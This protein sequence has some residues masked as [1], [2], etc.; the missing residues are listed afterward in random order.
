MGTANWGFKICTEGWLFGLYC[1]W[2]VERSLIDEGE[3][4]DR[5]TSCSREGRSGY[6]HKVA[7][8]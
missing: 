7:W 2:K 5:T 6:I 4:F 1:F 8:G 3:F